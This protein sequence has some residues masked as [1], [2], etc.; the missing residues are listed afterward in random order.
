MDHSISRRTF[1]KTS[2][3]TTGGFW[4]ATTP[5]FARKFSANEKLNLGVVGT[6]NRARANI[7]G[8]QSENIVAICDIDDQLLAA[9]QAKF[10][11]ARTYTDFR[12]MLGQ[13]DLD[14]V[15]ISTP[16]HTHAAATMAALKSGR[17]V[18]C[19]KPL[20]HDVFEVRAV[21]NEAR[22]R[23]VATQ[24]G[25]QIHA[26]AN[27]RRVVELIEAG[28]IG[29]VSEVH[30]WCERIWEGQGRP[31][32]TPP[33]PAGLHWDLWLGPAP[34]RPYHPTYHP[35]G[36]R[37]WW[38]FGGGTLGDMGCH[39]MDLPFW[40][41]KLRAPTKIEAE[42]PPPQAETTPGWLIVRYQFPARGPLPGT[43]LTWYNGGKLPKLIEE[44][45]VPDWQAGVL[46]VGTKGMLLADYSRRRLLPE[47]DFAG[48][49]P[50]AP[51]IPDS[52]GHHEEWI[53]ACKGGAPALCNFNYSGP[54]TEAVLLGNAAYR[55]GRSLE[56]NTAACKVTNTREA[57]PFIRRR[58]RKGWKL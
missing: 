28:T 14:A 30:V 8:V 47:A 26:T 55:T 10:P 22:K 2:L 23:K 38:D 40:A 46:F 51:S 45:K 32:E 35:K 41:L 19:E 36:W 12:R 58:Y 9:A 50:P 6:I 17:H 54:L 56:W 43:Q 16:D 3:L 57:D 34:A 48:F 15:V 31:V 52:I 7:N 39:Y 44:G 1:L 27:Y 25:T 4:L 20:A 5:G 11:R 53:A 33:V 37:R 13:R 42:G 21:T 29:L 18:Y 49:A 24:M